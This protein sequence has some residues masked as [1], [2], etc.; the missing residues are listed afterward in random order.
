M[1]RGLW[2]GLLAMMAPVKAL[3]GGAA[4]NGSNQGVGIRLDGAGVTHEV[5]P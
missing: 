3:K 2:L 5:R 4:K 1:R